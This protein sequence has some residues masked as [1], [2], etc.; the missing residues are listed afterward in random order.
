MIQVLKNILSHLAYRNRQ[1]DTLFCCI[2]PISVG[3]MPIGQMTQKF[4]KLCNSAYGFSVGNM[5][6]R[7][8]ARRQNEMSPN[9]GLSAKFRHVLQLTCYII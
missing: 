1:F 5:L 2:Q 9:E 3:K 7:Q 8:N 4:E 6:H